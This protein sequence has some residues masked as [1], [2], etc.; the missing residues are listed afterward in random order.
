MASNEVDAALTNAV[1][2]V[3]ARRWRI[4]FIVLAID[5]A[6]TPAIGISQYLNNRNVTKTATALRTSTIVQ[7]KAA[8]AVCETETMRA[9][10]QRDYSAFL[11]RQQ[12]QGLLDLQRF[13]SF[14]TPEVR[15][16]ALRNA[17]AQIDAITTLL[18]AFVPVDCEKQ[19]LIPE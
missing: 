2:N 10:A 11:L 3:H 7:A 5:L 4:V 8:R 1:R 15:A 13:P 9:Q 16:L 17:Q 18:Q 6:V 12:Q 19:F 14:N